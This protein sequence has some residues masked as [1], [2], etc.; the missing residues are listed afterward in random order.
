MDFPSMET[1]IGIVIVMHML[2]GT[3]L[4]MGMQF[5]MLM[6]TATGVLVFETALSE[7][8]TNKAAAL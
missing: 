5:V 8:E 6:G 7:T 2:T 1:D 3:E 4:L